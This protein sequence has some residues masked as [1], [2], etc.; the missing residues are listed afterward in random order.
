MITESKTEPQSA[1]LKRLV[2]PPSSSVSE[3]M[4]RMARTDDPWHFAQNLNA[5]MRLGYC[6]ACGM[7]PV[8]C[9]REGCGPDS[10]ESPV[11]NT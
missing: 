9:E 11:P 4:V 1:S 3:E 10:E 6:T 7:V 8:G 5:M 2:R